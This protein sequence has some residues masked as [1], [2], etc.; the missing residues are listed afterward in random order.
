[1]QTGG[2]LAALLFGG[3]L[4]R[5]LA[6]GLVRFGEARPFSFEGLKQTAEALAGAPYS[7]PLVRA[8]DVL[9]TIDYDAHNR[10]GFD[11]DATL[12]GEDP[13][14]PAVRFFHL[15]RYFKNPVNVSVVGP[16]GSARE[17]LYSA[18]LFTRPLDSPSR[19]LPDDIG[20]AGLRV[21]DPGQKDDWLA[22]LGASYW[23]TSGPF[24]QFGLSTRGLAVDTAIPNGSE[25]F[26]RFTSFWLEATGENSL[27]IHALMDSES[28]AGAYRIESEKREDGI[29]QEVEAAL[30][31]RE[32]VERLG[33]APLTSMYWYGENSRHL[34][35][36]W[37]PEIHDSD[38]LEIWSGNGERIFRPLNNPPHVMVNSF[39]V[40]GPKGFGL[41]QRDRDFENYQDD[42]VFY[43][44]R[45]SLWVEPLGDW[46]EG[47]VDLVELPT[48]DEIHD[49]IVAFWTPS[50]PTAPGRAMTM[51][52]RLSW[53][54]DNPHP[55]EVATLASL[56]IGRG[57]VPGQPRP[58]GVAKFALDFRG[59]KLKRLSRESGVAA[60][61]EA[62]RG[63]IGL[64]SAYP[65]V[66]TDEWRLL[67]DLDAQG[68]EPVDLRVYLLHEGDA[69]TETVLYQF[70]PETFLEKMAAMP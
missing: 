48:D 29:V 62:S 32:A 20:F 55:A 3:G 24:G 30:Y 23:R 42:G 54:A 67:F 36:D 39:M 11:P 40:T 25:E 45:A 46:S 18:D 26:P 65:V 61:I 49:N 27:V 56:R 52:Y 16:D 69:L 28:V 37:R 66:G 41:M 1:M 14:S 17:L 19:R 9:E 51:R 60:K 57:G 64:V 43:E 70:F 53:V 35:S 2:A 31:M 50:E 13:A 21:M 7:K 5:A 44:K 12:W 68:E 38:G 34:A 33:I 22:F 47:C 59:E 58:E 15:G 63:E 4:D 8:A 10:I 6:E